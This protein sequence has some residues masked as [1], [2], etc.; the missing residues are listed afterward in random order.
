METLK[1]YKFIKHTNI[2]SLETSLG[3]GGSGERLRCIMSRD[4]VYGAIHIG[5]FVCT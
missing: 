2:G 3:Y 5:M 4:D 1:L